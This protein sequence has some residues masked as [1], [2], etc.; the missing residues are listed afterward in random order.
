MEEENRFNSITAF[1][2]ERGGGKTLSVLGSNYCASDKDKA[3]NVIGL[4]DL[5]IKIK[6]MK[7]LIID[8]FDH[9]A[10]RKVPIMP[11][12]LFKEWKSGVYRLITHADLV[13][14]L[15][16]HIQQFNSIW[17]TCIIFEDSHKYLNSKISKPFLR[18]MGDTKQKNIDLFFMY[19]SF[20]QAPPDL[21]RMLDYI[22]CFKSVESPMVRAKQ[23]ESYLDHAIDIYNKV[24]K[25]PSPFYHDTIHT[26]NN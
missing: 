26:R 9:P 22:E 13:S 19:W 24:Q 7:I 21:F 5:Y 18:L 1:V 12:E 20:G 16:D 4:F 14:N 6:K 25:H 2:A 23:M 8:T 17:N 3:L 11:I 10:Y 15:V